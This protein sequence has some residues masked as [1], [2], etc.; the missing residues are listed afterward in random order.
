MPRNTMASARSC[1]D[2]SRLTD[3][4]GRGDRT[5]TCNR[6]FWRPVLYQ[7]SY[8]PTDAL[9]PTSSPGAACAAGIA[10]RTCSAPSG[11]G[12]FACSCGCCTC[13]PC[14]WCTPARSRVD[15]RPWPRC[16]VLVSRPSPPTPNKGLVTGGKRADS[17]LGAE[18]DVNATRHRL[19]PEALT[20]LTRG[21]PTGPM[22]E[23]SQPAQDLA[24]IVDAARRMGVELDEAEALR[25]LSAMA[26]DSGARSSSMPGAASSGTGSACSTSPPPTSPTSARWAG[27]SASRI[28]PG[29]RPRWPSPG[30]AA[31]SKIQTNPGDCDYFERINIHAPTREEAC[32]DARRPDAGEGARAPSAARRIG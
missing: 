25:W 10:G 15:F 7:L 20:R 22:T 27:S 4:A 12:R 9:L 11:Q 8:T 26:A 29:S 16:D 28:G 31:Q 24:R 5:R 23:T 2:G 13:A 21:G 3:E 17:R 32:R 18:A 19:R 30:S 14:R 1:C 6:W